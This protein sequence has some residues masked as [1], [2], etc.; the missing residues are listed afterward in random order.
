[1]FNAFVSTCAI[2]FSKTHKHNKKHR[3]DFCAS[4]QFLRRN[5]FAVLIHQVIDWYNMK[6]IISPVTQ[7]K[8]YILAR[9]LFVHHN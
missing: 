4:S 2:E 9:N 7:G 3:L 1:M 5:W 6:H 8:M